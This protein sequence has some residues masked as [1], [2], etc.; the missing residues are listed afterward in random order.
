MIA[1]IIKEG[2]IV[3]GEVTIQLLKQAILEYPDSEN[4]TF[5]IDGFPREMKQA[6]DFERLVSP[7]TYVL[8]FDCPLNVLEARLLER[9]KTSGRSDD[10]IESIKKR[11]VTFQQQSLPVIEYF[12]ALGKVEKLDSSKSIDQVFEDAQALHEKYFSK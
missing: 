12:S 2:R 6:L 7:C 11:F 10:N 3:P 9:G 5:L 4:S 1:N 8:F